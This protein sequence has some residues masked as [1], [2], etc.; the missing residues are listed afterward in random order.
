MKS[1]DVSHHRKL[2]FQM[3]AILLALPTLSIASSGPVLRLST[4][5]SATEKKARAFYEPLF[6]LTTH[7]GFGRPITA[8][9]LR[10][11]VQVVDAG[12]QISYWSI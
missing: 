8:Y 3:A 9:L 7:P 10:R 11:N 12:D 4:R 5:H 2:L 6:R 1:L